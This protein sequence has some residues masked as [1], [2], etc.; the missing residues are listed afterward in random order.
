[1]SHSDLI[2]YKNKKN[3]YT[4][5]LGDN[6]QIIRKIRFGYVQLNAGEQFVLKEDEKY[7]RCIVLL[8]GK[9]TV[10]INDRQTEQIGFRASVFIDKAWAVYLGIQDSVFIQA[11]IPSEFAVCSVP[12]DEK[13][14]AQVICPEKVREVVRG[15]NAYMRKVFDIV[16][17]DFPAQRMIVGETLNPPANWS[18]FPP[19][20]HD[21]ERG[22]EEA[23]LE[24]IYY[25]RT[26]PSDG[27][28][29][30]RIYDETKNIDIPLSVKD[31]SVVLIPYGYHPVAAAPGYALYYLWVLAGERRVLIPYEDPKY[32]WINT[33]M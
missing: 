20:K 26:N 11:D 10:K 25:F 3:G 13:F 29:Y 6:Q 23:A 4:D 8:K 19:H 22:D 9:C 1:M 31:H 21:C 12:A 15:E 24:E 7:E 28:G 5:F 2:I 33:G 16:P 14:P 32:R 30:Q 18:S 17:P 27:F